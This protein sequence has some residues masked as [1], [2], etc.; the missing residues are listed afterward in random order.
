[1]KLLTVAIPCYNSQAYMA[2]AIESILPAGNAVEIIIVD[3]GSKDD[4]L[5]IAQDYERRYPDIVR[6]VHKENGGHGDA[7]MTGVRN[8]SG[9]YFKVLDSDDWFD[10]EAFARTLNHLRRHRRKR[11]GIVMPWARRYGGHSLDRYAE[12]I[13][14]HRLF[15]GRSHVLS[16]SESPRQ[17]ACP[18]TLRILSHLDL[19]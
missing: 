9:R 10:T 3:D 6:A 8:A 15:C 2:H 1:M 19:L 13:L 11:A 7:V 12:S 18:P 16:A 5:Q 14:R 4:T 17:H